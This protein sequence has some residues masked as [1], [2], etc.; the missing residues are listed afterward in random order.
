MATEK[1]TKQAAQPAYVTKYNIEELADAAK[2]AFG[3]EKVVV[4]AALRL[5]GKDS[6]TM[7]EATKIVNAFKSKEVRK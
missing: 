4:L 1:A 6:Y 2:T 3:T 7:S 5:A